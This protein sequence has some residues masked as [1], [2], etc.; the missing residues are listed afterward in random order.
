MPRILRL[1]LILCL[2]IAIVGVSIWTTHWWTTNEL[3]S[4]TAFWFPRRVHRDYMQTA[5]GLRLVG[6]SEVIT[7]REEPGGR[8]STVWTI[9]RRKGG[10]VLDLDALGSRVTRRSGLSDVVRIAQVFAST[11]QDERFG[12]QVAYQHVELTDSIEIYIA[13]MPVGDTH[14]SYAI[15]MRRSDGTSAGR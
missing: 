13:E 6:N 11:F 2:A 8:S 14:A 3:K 5:M 12:A 7:C 10:S 9:V 1:L 4:E 15:V